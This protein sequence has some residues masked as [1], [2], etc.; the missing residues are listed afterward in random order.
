MKSCFAGFYWFTSTK[1]NSLQ[2]MQQSF[3]AQVVQ[4]TLTDCSQ[5]KSDDDLI[6]SNSE[7]NDND[8]TAK[9]KRHKLSIGERLIPLI[10][11][12]PFILCTIILFIWSFIITAAW[13]HILLNISPPY[14]TNDT[15][16]SMD[17]IAYNLSIQNSFK[18]LWQSG[19]YGIALLIL[20]LSFI[21]PMI[22]LLYILLLVL[23]N[24]FKDKQF[25]IKIIPN[26]LKPDKHKNHS[27]ILIVLEVLNKYSFI[28]IF[29]LVILMSCIYV[30]ID[31]DISL[32]DKI[33]HFIPKNVSSFHVTSTIIIEPDAGIVIF[34]VAMIMSSFLTILIKYRYI[35]FYTL[36]HNVSNKMSR[37]QWTIGPFS[38][39]YD[40][41]YSYNNPYPD[42]NGSENDEITTPNRRRT[43]RYSEPQSPLLFSKNYSFRT[44][45][46]KMTSFIFFV[47]VV[48]GA[49]TLIIAQIAFIEVEYIGELSNFMTNPPSQRIYSLDGIVQSVDQENNNGNTK[50]L[51]I[52]Y[53]LFGIVLPLITILLLI[54]LWMIPMPK[55]IHIR[56]KG[57]IWCSHMLNSIDV[58]I[59]SCIIIATELPQLFEY[60]VKNQY[61]QYCLSLYN[62][63]GLNL[64]DSMEIKIYLHDGIWTG[65]AFYISLWIVVTYSVYFSEDDYSPKQLRKLKI[66]IKNL[67]RQDSGGAMFD[68]IDENKTL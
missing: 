6:D 24:S 25:F 36:P 34:G 32:D 39:M 49:I 33:S 59:I 43:R 5:R 20:L 22:K 12:I 29:I 1:N 54:L 14:D 45:C 16:Y 31:N 40:S 66:K 27:I 19:S 67:E 58:I 10:I 26:F 8:N 52:I 35:P 53:E 60:I 50:F 28:N 30:N 56:L 46:I 2:T 42:D 4:S 13:L 51:R 9:R 61:K 44:F 57:I 55:W 11:L 65:I 7:D 64:C 62:E 38:R 17:K 47:F 68:T 37:Q 15:I 23:S 21:F 48:I 18:D 3:E 63:L 41:K